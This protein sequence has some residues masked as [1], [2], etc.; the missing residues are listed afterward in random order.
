MTTKFKIEA[1]NVEGPH[2]HVR[3][4]VV[5]GS[6][7]AVSKGSELG[8]VRLRSALY[9]QDPRT[10]LFELETPADAARLRIGAIVELTR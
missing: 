10:Y 4:S 8:G 2:A 7:F 9:E 3:A 6:Y 1:I 5:Q